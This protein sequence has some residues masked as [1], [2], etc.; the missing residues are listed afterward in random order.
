MSSFGLKEALDIYLKQREST[1]KIWGYFSAVSLAVL[2]YTVGSDKVNW[3]SLTYLLIGG[4][5]V[6][7]AIANLFVLHSS[8]VA[9]RSYADGVNSLAGTH[10]PDKYF[11]ARSMC[12][13]LIALFHIGA[14]AIIVVAIWLTWDH[15]CSGWLECPRQLSEQ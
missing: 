7:F 4:G 9:L 13:C 11:S 5:Y 1:H 14:T 8:Q 6:I 15:H 12:P 2:G 3:S 10:T